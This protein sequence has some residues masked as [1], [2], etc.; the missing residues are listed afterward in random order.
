[1]KNKFKYCQREIENNSRCKIQCDHCTEYYKPLEEKRGGPGR[2]QGRK[3]PFKEKT[4]SFKVTYP[5]SK[6][7]ELKAHIKVKLDQWAKEGV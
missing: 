3:S 4:D 2:G 5:E 1:M 6:R 7:A